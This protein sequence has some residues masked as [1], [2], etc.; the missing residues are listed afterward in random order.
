MEGG[1]SSLVECWLGAGYLFPLDTTNLWQTDTREIANTP[2]FPLSQIF[3]P[4]VFS[5]E[6]FALP[7]SR[8]PHLIARLQTKRLILPPEQPKHQ[9]TFKICESYISLAIQS[10]LLQQPK[11]ISRQANTSSR[12]SS[13][14]WLSN[15]RNDT[16]W[17]RCCT[18][19]AIGLAL[20]A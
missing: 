9:W 10:F 15:L 6:L 20:N 13:R 19:E 17:F 7:A 11:V 14:L 5:S 2:H 18:E 16:G 8:T 4:I 12:G 1:A 3:L